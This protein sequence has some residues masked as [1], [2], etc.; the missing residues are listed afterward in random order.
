MTAHRPP[1]TSDAGTIDTAMVLAAGLGTRMRPLTDRIPKPMVELAGR[2]LIDHALDRLATAG[3][4]KAVVNVHYKADQI[5]RHLKH[6]KKPA[7]TISDERDALLDTGGGLVRAL[8]LLGTRPFI[9]HNSDTAWIEGVGCNLTRL[10]AAWDPDEMD[11]LLLLALGSRSLG[12]SSNGDFN[13]DPNGRLTRRVAPFV[14]PFVFTGVSI[15]HPRL[16]EGA[17][18]GAAFS[19]NRLW[20]RAIEQG[21]L[22][23]I[24]L[25]G[26]WMHVGTPEAIVE[27]EAWIADANKQA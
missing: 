25:D 22:Y 18:S 26:W 10:M 27:A 20:N 21:R 23:G 19:L 16:F 2:P 17:P 11:C 6:R 15:A 3:I 12:Y 4:K 5:E 13:M 14:A 8:P 24:R 1:K 9:I 7:I